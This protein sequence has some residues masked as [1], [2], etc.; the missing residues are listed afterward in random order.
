LLFSDVSCPSFLFTTSIRRF[1]G[2]AAAVGDGGGRK[3]KEGGGA[4]CMV[5]RGGQGEREGKR[6]REL[7]AVGRWWVEEGRAREKTRGRGS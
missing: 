7:K 3:W 1:D 2:G 5:G 4:G 6:A